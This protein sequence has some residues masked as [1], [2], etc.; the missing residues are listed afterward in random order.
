MTWLSPDARLISGLAYFV[1][2]DH[3]ADLFLNDDVALVGSCGDVTNTTDGVEIHEVENYLNGTVAST[4]H[5]QSDWDVV[6]IYDLC[7]LASRDGEQVHAA[8]L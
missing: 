2:I 5:D 7:P 6:L 1:T 8:H 4:R 3:V